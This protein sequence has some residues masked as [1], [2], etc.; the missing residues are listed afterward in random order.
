MTRVVSQ[1]HSKKTKKL[2]SIL[3]FRLNKDFNELREEMVA[4]WVLLVNLDNTA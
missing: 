4:A 1:R 2:K 3:H